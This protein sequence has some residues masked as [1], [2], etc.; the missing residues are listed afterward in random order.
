M[1][2]WICSYPRSG[3]TLTRTVLKRCFDALSYTVYNSNRA[4]RLSDITGGAPFDGTAEELVA[5]AR[6][7]SSA[8][9]VKTHDCKAP[10]EDRMLYIVRD[11]RAAISSFRRF[12]STHNGAKFSLEEMVL[13]VPPVQPWAAHAA[14]G[15]ARPAETTL[16]LHFEDLCQPNEKTL[17]R[18][19]AFTG[20]PVQRALDIT[21]D[22]LHELQPEFFG[23][24]SNGPG[25]EEIEAAC[26]ALFWMVNG[27]AM[28]QHGYTNGERAISA[29]LC[30]GAVEE[31]RRFAIRQRAK[32]K[33]NKPENDKIRP[34]ERTNMRP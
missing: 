5:A 1:L 31:M 11:G 9:F 22:H 7:S 24:G 29:Q 16:V 8:M 34:A 30:A 6:A 28:R 10:D 18:I 21:F 23:V 13:G 14:W 12:Q 15:A 4:G 33:K 20:L 26:P 2:F 25:I 17:D 32:I 19:A 27:G 3:N